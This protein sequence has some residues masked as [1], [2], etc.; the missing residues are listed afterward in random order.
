MSLL[1]GLKTL[2]KA[3]ET[4]ADSLSRDPTILTTSH[5]LHDA[6]TTRTSSGV[7]RNESVSTSS[8][9][10]LHP[11]PHLNSQESLHQYYSTMMLQLQ[12]SVLQ[13][14]P[15]SIPNDLLEAFHSSLQREV[16]TYRVMEEIQNAVAG[17]VQGTTTLDYQQHQQQ[18]GM[19]AQY[20]WKE[21]KANTEQMAKLLIQYI[22]SKT[23]HF[24][25]NNDTPASLL[26]LLQCAT[27]ISATPQQLSTYASKGPAELQQVQSLLSNPNVMREI[28]EAT[29]TVSNPERNDATLP[30]GKILQIFHTILNQSNYHLSMTKGTTT[31]NNILHRLALATALEFSLSTIHIFDTNVPIDPIQRYLHYEQAYVEGSLDP[32]FST[33]STWELRMVVNSDASNDELAWCRSMLRNYRPDHTLRDDYY[34]K[35]CIIVKTDVQY[36]RP[37]WTTSPRTYQQLLS[38]GGMCGPRAWFGRFVCK[39][40]GIPTWGVR[41][42][43]H[44]ALSH[45]M[46]PHQHPNYDWAICLGGPNWN[47]SYWDGLNGDDFSMDVKARAHGD[48]AYGKVLMLQ[49]IAKVVGETP[50]GTLPTAYD[51][52]NWKQRCFWGHLSWLQ[53]RILAQKSLEK[54]RD[55]N[56]S[57]RIPRDTLCNLTMEE[58]LRATKDHYQIHVDYIDPIGGIITIPAASFQDAKRRQNIIVMRSYLVEGKNNNMQVHLRGDGCLEYG[59]NLRNFLIKET[60]KYALTLRVVNV[61]ANLKPLNV[62]I[63]SGTSEECTVHSVKIPYTMGQWQYTLPLLIELDVQNHNTICF[64][65]DDPDALGLSIKDFVLK[66]IYNFND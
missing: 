1:R 64:Y 47:K 16:D 45:W 5:H 32:Y 13:L 18:L 46:P 55:G 40:F 7:N 56:I 29:N 54:D 39:A 31:T 48:Q 66:P 58:R 41:Q 6:T 9:L 60:T 28:L 37:E 38:G 52:K 24:F 11:P 59:L 21:A 14:L 10:I 25:T 49:W 36:K 61:S 34:W 8:C 17:E 26:S 27:L 12:S 62:S 44:A 57:L 65:R 53:K 63:K 20:T 43:G 42:P 4:I 3:L 2:E 23:N 50:I 33:L 30:Y 15:S 19:D 35:Y 51:R 22:D